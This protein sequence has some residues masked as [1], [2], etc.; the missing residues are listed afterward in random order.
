MSSRVLD[1]K[2]YIGGA[3]NVVMLNLFPR[4]QKTFN[5]NFGLDIT[6]YTFSA[7]Y[8]SIVIDQLAYERNTGNPNFANSRVIGYQDNE[9]QVDANVFITVQDAVTGSVNFTIPE[10]R[11]TGALLPSARELV[12]ITVVSFEWETGETPPQKDSHRYAIIETWEPGVEPGDPT[13]ETGFVSL[14]AGV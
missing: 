9:T 13:D 1:F 10:Q 11:Y 3:D 8:H 5:Y 4:S 12:V 7:D 6:N 2:E 14:I